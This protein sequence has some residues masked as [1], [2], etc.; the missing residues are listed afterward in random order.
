MSVRHVPGPG[1]TVR[2]GADAVRGA[3]AG[4]EAQ[5]AQEKMESLRMRY[6]IVGQSSADTVHRLGQTL[7]AS[8]RLGT[9]QEDLALWLSRMEKELGCGDGPRG[10]QEPP[11]STSDREKVRDGGL[12]GGTVTLCPLHR[13]TAEGRGWRGRPAV[14]R[15]RGAGVC[16]PEGS[17]RCSRAP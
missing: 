15:G 12:W 14:P 4:E 6:L 10:G 11:V 2:S 7:E 3:A 5:L 13:G 16:V 9:A 1:V 8:S 17:P